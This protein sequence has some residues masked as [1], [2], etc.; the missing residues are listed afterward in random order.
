MQD[1]MQSSLVLGSLFVFITLSIGFRSPKQAAVTLIPILLVVVWLYGLMNAA[2]S[3]L[4]IVTVTI[5]TISLGVGIDYCIHVTERYIESREKGETHHEA[6]VAVGGA[7]SMALIGSA[8]SDS[9]GFLVIA[10][11]P[12]GLFSNFGIYSAAMIVL[13]LIASLILTTAA[14]GILSSIQEKKFDTTEE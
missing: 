14:L 8:A 10:I 4:N 11:S 7:C 9:A 6:L 5:A 1:E 13:S 12:M 2:G 3:S